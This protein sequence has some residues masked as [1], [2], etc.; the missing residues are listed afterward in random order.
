M[1][2]HIKH[3]V[4][5]KTPLIMAIYT[6]LSGKCVMTTKLEH[7]AMYIIYTQLIYASIQELT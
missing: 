7:D 5:D 3:N 2:L 6:I 1:H 4:Q